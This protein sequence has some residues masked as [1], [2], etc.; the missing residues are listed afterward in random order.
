MEESHDADIFIYDQMGPDEANQ[1]L[2][3]KAKWLSKNS[4]FS[5][6]IAG[7]QINGE[8]LWLIRD[9]RVEGLLTVQ[10]I[11]YDKESEE[12]KVNEPQRYMLS[13]DCGWIVNNSAPE[14]DSFFAVVDSSGG[15]IQMTD[16]NVQPHLP[17][18]LNVLDT[19][20][21]KM[22]NRVNPKV[23]QQTKLIGYT[24]YLT[25]VAIPTQSKLEA[26]T[27][28]L[29]EGMLIALSCP[30]TTRKTGQ[31]KVMK[32]PVTLLSDGI[33]YERL[34]L[35]DEFPGLEEGKHYYPNIRLKIIINYVS[36]TSLN[37]EEYWAKLQKIEED[38]QD[39]IL[40][41]TLKE[42]VLSPSGH[43]FEKSSIS[44]WISSKQV[45]LPSVSNTIPIPDPITDQDIRGKYLV[46]NKNLSQ[47]IKFWPDFY[48]NQEYQL[49]L[50]LSEKTL[51]P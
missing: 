40:S 49:A 12:W 22:E 46:P 39:P 27:V 14:S 50:M 6:K 34:S 32:D 51:S 44:Q 9:S 19:N 37:P 21:Y 43:S 38:I 29:P 30:M 13:N 7:L 15:L 23:G 18:L 47:F 36:A 45:N 10:S 5:L 41:T 20:G 33:S 42:P 48:Q 16:G 4:D 17:G 11:S 2:F 26:T 24:H 1:I 35:L 25:D 31:I 28:T 3:A 8:R